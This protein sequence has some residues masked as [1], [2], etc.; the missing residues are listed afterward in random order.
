MIVDR[1]IYVNG[2]RIST[3]D[4]LGEMHEAVQAKW[5]CLDRPAQTCA[6]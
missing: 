1:A 6:G 4:S 5:G 3:P 2:A